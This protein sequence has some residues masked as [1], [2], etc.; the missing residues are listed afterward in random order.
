MDVGHHRLGRHPF[1]QRDVARTHGLLGRGEGRRAR[2]TAGEK[3]RG[4]AE[5]EGEQLRE[6]QRERK[7]AER[8]HDRQREVPGAVLAQ[9]AEEAGA[10]LKADGEDEQHEP[11][12]LD[13]GME[14]EAEVPEDQTDEQHA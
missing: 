7:P 13:R 3:T 11:E 2:Q 12:G 14:F 6:A 5:V 8:D 9:H 10:G 1:G 4:S